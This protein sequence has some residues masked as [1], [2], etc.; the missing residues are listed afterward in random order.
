MESTLEGLRSSAVTEEYERNML[1]DDW[2][3]PSTE[4]SVVIKME[5]IQHSDKHTD[6]VN[7]SSTTNDHPVESTEP[8]HLLT[9]VNTS[10]DSQQGKKRSRSDD[11]SE[12]G[13]WSSDVEEDLYFLINMENTF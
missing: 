4:E 13:Y 1:D 5:P 11:E 3:E 12:E 9:E 2:V 6:S 8:T 7:P 10:N